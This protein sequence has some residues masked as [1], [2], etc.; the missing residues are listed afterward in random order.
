MNGYIC[1]YRGESIETRADSSY[2]AQTKTAVW[3]QKKNPRRKVRGYEI[4][5]KLAE[6]D[7]QQ[8]THTAVD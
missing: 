8:V 6:K 5:V 7:G 2:E 4:T 3:F 1:F